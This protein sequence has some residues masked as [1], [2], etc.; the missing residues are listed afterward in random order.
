MNCYRCLDALFWCKDTA[1]NLYPIDINEDDDCI[2]I[3]SYFRDS[4]VYRG[5]I[6]KL[7]ITAVDGRDIEGNDMPT[8]R[9]CYQNMLLS[10]IQVYSAKN[11]QEAPTW[12]YT[13]LKD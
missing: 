8:Q 3:I 10:K 2:E 9:D 7:I 6:G 5:C 13:F 12:K 11:Q 1:Y 4:D